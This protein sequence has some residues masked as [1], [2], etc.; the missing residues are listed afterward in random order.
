[1]D[2]DGDGVGDNS[3]ADPDDPDVRVPADIQINVTDKSIYVL[4]FAILIFTAAM[5]FVRKR[6]PAATSI[7]FVAEGDS[8]WNDA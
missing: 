3:D 1:M 4:A 2:T 7:P 6:P 8:I 5:V